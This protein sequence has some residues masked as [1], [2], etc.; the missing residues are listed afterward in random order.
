MEGLCIGKLIFKCLNERV[1][2]RAHTH[3]RQETV[4]LTLEVLE[5][6]R[7]GLMQLLSDAFGDSFSLFT[8]GHPSK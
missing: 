5:H 1:C 6:V 7:L 8:C 3:T 2:A 4:T